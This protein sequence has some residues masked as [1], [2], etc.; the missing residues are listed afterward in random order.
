MN[1]AIVYLLIKTI[2]AEFETRRKPKQDDEEKNVTLVHTIRKIR[3]RMLKPPVAFE[4]TVVI[5][6]IDNSTIDRRMS[7]R[8]R[9]SP[10][11]RQYGW[12]IGLGPKAPINDA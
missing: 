3:K 1:K 2:I 12:R 6:G 8:C 10:V 9:C 7:I 5:S 4:D 11:S